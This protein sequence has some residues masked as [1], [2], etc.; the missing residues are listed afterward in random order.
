MFVVVTVHTDAIHGVSVEAFGPW[1]RDKC[2]RER[3]RLLAD[4]AYRE[5]WDSRRFR[6]EVVQLR[7]FVIAP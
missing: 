2:D 3:R 1:E 7:N 6:V 4:F 5:R